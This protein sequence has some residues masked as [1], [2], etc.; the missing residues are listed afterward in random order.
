MIYRISNSHINLEVD[1]QGAEMVKLSTTSGR[2]YLWD[3]NPDT[4]ARNAPVLFPIVGKLINNSYKLGEETYYLPQHGFARDVA[5]K[6][7]SQSENELE[8]V[9]HETENTLKVYPFS[10]QLSIKYTLIGSTVSID[11]KIKNSS[12]KLLPFSIGAHPAF[13]LDPNVPLN[14]YYIEFEKAES[15]YVHPLVGGL[16]KPE[17]DKQI[18]LHNNKLALSASLFADDALIFSQL[19]SKWVALVHEASNYRVQVQIAGFP[20]LGIWGKDHVPFVCIEPWLGHADFTNHD[21][22]FYKKSGIITLEPQAHFSSSFSIT[23][24]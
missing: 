21:L 8:F 3:G 20:W 15:G 22:N 12:D 2:D 16:V 4:W 6:L 10:F 17:A 14:E 23:V 13:M 9:L 1:T 5:F 24:D 7:V 19:Q 18:P 11:Y